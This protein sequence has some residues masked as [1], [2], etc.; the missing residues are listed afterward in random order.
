MR[1]FI[2]VALA[3]SAGA[4]QAQSIWDAGGRVGPQF[5]Q[6]QLKSPVNQTISEFVLPVFVVIPVSPSFTFDVGTAY[7]SARVSA[8]GGP[9]TAASQ[10]N[11]FTDT[12]IRGNYTFGNDFVVLTAGVNLPTGRETAKPAEQLAAG[13]IGSDF[14]AFPITTMG[15]GFGGTFGLA[16]ARPMG[17]WNVGFGGSVRKSAAYDPYEDS[18]G[19]RLHYQPGDE[20][21]A[22]LGLDRGVGTGRFVL[23]LTYS[24]FGNDQAGGSIYNTGDRY[25][26]QMS[27][28]NNL[29]GTD[30]TLATWDLYRASGTLADGTPVGFD[31]VANALVALGFHPGGILVEPNLEVRNWQR[32]TF[33]PSTLVTAGLRMDF[34]IG[35]F[36]VT[37]SAGYTFG[38]LAAPGASGASQTF[39]DIAG[40]RAV[41]S[42]RFGG[43]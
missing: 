3:L 34:L 36:G 19:A 1:C 30:F 6:Y 4:L 21:R 10:I 41:L 12:Q 43:F 38:R 8:I 20:Y 18:K 22:R 26:T 13:R 14:L 31:N 28:T 17:D 11:G 32:D 42:V 39:A 23:G 40:F 15:T 5:V 27:L 37:P 33:L 9:D 2:P 35:G 24:K 16:V 7:T 25:V 29:A